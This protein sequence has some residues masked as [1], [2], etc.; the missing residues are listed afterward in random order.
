MREADGVDAAL[1]LINDN[2]DQNNSKLFGSEVSLSNIDA[3]QCSD[4][5]LARKKTEPRKPVNRIT[6]FITV[7][8]TK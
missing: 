5:I 2:L 3:S 4:P 6:E 8:A 7:S 1:K